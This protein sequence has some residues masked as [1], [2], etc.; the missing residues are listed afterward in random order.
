MT[1]TEDFVVSSFRQQSARH[2]GSVP[3]RTK[4]H[5]QRTLWSV[6][7]DTSQRHIVDQF[8]REQSDTDRGICGHAV[9]FDTISHGKEARQGETWSVPMRTEWQRQRSLWSINLGTVNQDQVAGRR[10]TCSVPMRTEWQRQ[11]SLWSILAS[12]KWQDEE[13]HAQYQWELSDRDSEVCGQFC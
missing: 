9:V 2:C 1:Q 4:W 6:V 13:R 10:E 3:V 11:R 8:Q 5:R 7:F 12:G